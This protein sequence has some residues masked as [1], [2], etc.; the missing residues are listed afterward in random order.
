[1]STRKNQPVKKVNLSKN[2]EF[3]RGFSDEHSVKTWF[4]ENPHAIGLAV[5]GK[6]NVGKSTLIN[7][8]FSH[9]IARASKTPGKT[10]EINLFKFSFEHYETQKIH[11]LYLFDL[12]GFGYARVA[13]E[14][15]SEW[16]TLMESF[17]REAPPSVLLLYLQDSRLPNG[18]TDQQFMSYITP[19]DRPSFLVFSKLDKLNQKERAQLSKEEKNL[20]LLYPWIME[21]HQVSAEENRGIDKLKDR[22]AHYI[23]SCLTRP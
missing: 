5:V 17:F 1:M 23:V 12:P 21:S 22:I 2:I 15:Q 18:S 7:A 20:Q 16:P 10:R 8:L 19:Y 14:L 3:V 9:K 11:Q 4:E 13:K 6:S